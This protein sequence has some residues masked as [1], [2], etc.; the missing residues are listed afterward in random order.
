MPEISRFYGIIIR[1][2]TPDHAPPHFHAVYAE[3]EVS[4]TIDP[5]GILAG[6]LP[7]KALGLV[8][9]WASLHQDQLMDNWNLLSK[10]QSPN[11]IEPLK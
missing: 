1:M 3:H 11:R 9:E 4:I 5:I 2:F 10:N 8:T 7:P 6:N